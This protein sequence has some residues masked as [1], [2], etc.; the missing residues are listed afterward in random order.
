MRINRY[1]S[2]AGVCSRREADRK[3]ERGEVRIDGRVATLGDKVEDGSEVLVCGKQVHPSGEKVVYLLNKPVGYVCTRNRREGKTVE[4]LIRSPQRVYPVGRLDKASEGLLL[5][6]NDGELSNNIQRARNYHEKEYVVRVDRPVDEAFIRGMSGGVPILDTVT[7]KC[8]IKRIG[9]F[10][11][12]IVLTQGLNR[13]IRRMC[14]YFGYEVETLKRIRVMNM[15][16][17]NLKPGEYRTAT[18][19]ELKELYRL[20]GG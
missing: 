6:T 5:M 4:E 19:K 15:L 12:D 10:E 7:R 2:D 16:L 17:G 11:F 8:R 20:I 1:L 18:E 3:I 13:Q 9:E 14:E